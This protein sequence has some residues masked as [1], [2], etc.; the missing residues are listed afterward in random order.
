MQTKILK[1]PTM[2]KSVSC[3]VG[4][5]VFFVGLASTPAY[6]LTFDWSFVVTGGGGVGFP[7]AVGGS[8]SGI[9]DGLVE[10]SA[11]QCTGSNTCT[12]E[13][14]SVPGGF[15]L[16]G[17]WQFNGP[18]NGVGAAFSVSGGNVTFANAR[19]TRGNDELLF[20]TSP[21]N[22]YYPQL[23]GD[24]PGGVI[25]YN[26]LNPPSLPGVTVFSSSTRTSAVPGPLPLFGAATAFGFSRKLRKRIKS[27][28][29]PVSSSYTI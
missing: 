20:G 12:V 2:N 19:F 17:G 4:T 25:S 3:G 15:L 29:N 10:G 28:A 16:G 21:F 22:T 6:A 1:W 7:S 13:I 11:N 18:P 26:S 8:V 5:A 9:I 23:Q 27:S 14:T 24:V